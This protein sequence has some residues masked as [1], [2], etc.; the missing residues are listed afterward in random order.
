[1]SHQSTAHA[2]R[3]GIEMVPQELSLAPALSAAENM[4]VG[5]YPARLGRV[6][7]RE[8]VRTAQAIGERIGLKGD[9]R[10]PAGSLS[11]SD[12][13]LVMI[14]RALVRDVKLLILDE[15]TASLPEDEV[16]LLLGV[17]RSSATRA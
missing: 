2:V 3:L 7:W 8:M 12:Q 17:L 15:P 4:F 11:P 10:R 16:T 13:R 1:M 9:L 14:G 5:H 6:R